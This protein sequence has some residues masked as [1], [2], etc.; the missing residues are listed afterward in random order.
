MILRVSLVLLS[1]ILL[2][3]HF[4][5]AGNLLLMAL[6]LLLPALLLIRR[7]WSLWLLQ[8]FAYLGAF[9]WL[10]TLAQIV[11][12][13]MAVGRSYGASVAILGAVALLTLLSGALLNSAVI[14]RRYAESPTTERQDSH[15][16]T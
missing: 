14:R 9:I 4:L 10:T 15:D 13:R 3:A 2:A 11:L 7:P 6:C 16:T 5:R 8:G 12:A 1:A